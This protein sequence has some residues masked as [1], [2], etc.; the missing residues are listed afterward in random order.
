ML[1]RES[2]WIPPSDPAVGR[3]NRPAQGR[4]HCSVKLAQRSLCERGLPDNLD[5]LSYCQSSQGTTVYTQVQFGAVTE[6]K[7]EVFGLGRFVAGSE[8]P[9]APVTKLA[10][11][12][13]ILFSRPIAN[14][15]DSLFR[16]VSLFGFDR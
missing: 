11:N 7:L 4:E 2:S 12:F 16:V 8:R 5:S 6:D 13:I 3:D 15:S 9:S 10:K 1:V 14:I